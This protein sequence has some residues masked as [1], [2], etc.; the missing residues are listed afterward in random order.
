MPRAAAS[1]SLR[2]FSRAMRNTGMA[3]PPRAAAW[4]T[5]STLAVEN[6]Q[7]KGTRK[8][9]MNEVWSPYKFRPLMVMN[10]ALNLLMSHRPWSKI[11]KSKAWVPKPAWLRRVHEVKSQT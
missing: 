2:S 3:A 1:R 4:D 6:T 7:A 10:G 8:T 11:P 5:R 9:M